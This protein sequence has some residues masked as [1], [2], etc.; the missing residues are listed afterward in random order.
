MGQHERHQSQA[1]SQGSFATPLT[2]TLLPQTRVSRQTERDG[3]E[4]K[5]AEVGPEERQVQA[6]GAAEEQTAEEAEEQDC[7]EQETHGR[8][9]PAK[10]R[11]KPA[12]N[13]NW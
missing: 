3:N 4:Y 9:S 8:D 7:R 10:A 1:E 2:K 5:E 12:P 6:S 13:P 11:S